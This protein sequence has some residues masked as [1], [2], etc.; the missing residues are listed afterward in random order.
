M[1]PTLFQYT[2]ALFIAAILSA[3]NNSG[4]DAQLDPNKP[5][6]DYKPAFAGQTRIDSVK[7]TTP[8][9]VDK[10]AEHLG[11][12]WAITAM[13]GGKF[14]ITDKSGFMQILSAEGVV[15]KKITAFLKWMIMHKAVCLM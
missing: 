8:Y 7:T 5:N 10:L 6:S 14:I 1:K 13:P 4:K 3:C 15:L 2:A 11:K 12:P 9:K